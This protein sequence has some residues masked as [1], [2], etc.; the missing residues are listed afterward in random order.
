MFIGL[1]MARTQS[2]TYD[3]KQNLIITHAGNLFA[4]H[5][6]LGASVASIA[7][8]CNIS[9]SL[10]Y[11]YFPSKEDILYAIMSQHLDHLVA[12]EEKALAL[13]SDDP[14]IRLRT[15][16]SGLVSAYVGA[17][18]SHKVLLNELDNLPADKRAAI[19][20]RQREIITNVEALLVAIRPELKSN[21]PLV[22]PVSLLFFGMV[23]W[24]HTWFHASGPVSP[25]QLANM[26]TDI[27]LAGLMQIK[28]DDHPS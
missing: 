25:T 22:R 21:E 7:A 24:T 6:F 4:R 3:D 12:I 27:M 2:L 9:K 16:T 18:A 8:V 26:V 13:P 11:H 20:A 28:I 15:L 14:A 23:N 5:G 10:V 1:L 19:I 17:A